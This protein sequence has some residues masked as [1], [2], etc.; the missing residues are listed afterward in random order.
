MEHDIVWHDES[1]EESPQ[2]EPVEPEAVDSPTAR[3]LY[4]ERDKWRRRHELFV[5]GTWASG[6]PTQ[7]PLMEKHNEWCRPQV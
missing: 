2:I 4:M 6:L 3:Q 5:E 1:D 7:D